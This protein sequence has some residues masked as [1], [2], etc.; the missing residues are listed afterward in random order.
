MIRAGRVTVDGRPAHLGQKIDPEREKVLIDGLPQPVRPD[1]VYLLLNKP[2]GVI[3]TSDD[4]QGRPTVIGLVGGDR[5][6]YPVGRLDADSEGLLLLTND[7]EFTMLLTHPRHGIAKTYLALVR[8]QPG[9]AAIRALVDG[10]ALED[11]PARAI[12][13][14]IIDRGSAS[15]LVEIV[16]TEGRNRQ[17]RRMMDAVGHPVLRLARTAIG[18]LRDG[19]LAPGEWRP[20]TIEEIRSLYR[21]AVG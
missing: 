18:P 20:L 15:A 17:V 12:S 19:D 4:P 10:V 21:S 2:A 13:A 7:G 3:S 14:Q 8:G 1:L 6:L 11:G 9:R 16:I 5:R